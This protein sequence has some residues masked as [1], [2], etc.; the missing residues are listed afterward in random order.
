M[1]YINQKYLNLDKSF[2]DDL[3]NQLELFCE[4]LKSEIWIQKE[5]L[6]REKLS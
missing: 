1:N 6:Q 3:Q 4:K 2:K 5:N